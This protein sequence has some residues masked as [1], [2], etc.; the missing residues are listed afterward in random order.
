M[1]TTHAMAEI[2]TGARLTAFGYLEE[3]ENICQVAAHLLGLTADS[4][5]WKS[6]PINPDGAETVCGCARLRFAGQ[7]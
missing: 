5:F 1:T 6:M 2:C 7:Q 3:L 4:L